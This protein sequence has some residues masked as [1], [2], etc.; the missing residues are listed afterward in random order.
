MTTPDLKHPP[1]KTPLVPA[2]HATAL[3][4]YQLAAVAMRRKIVEMGYVNH[5]RLHYGALMSMVEIM[6]ALYGAWLNVDPARPDWPERDRFVLSKGH[7]APALYVA[8]WLRG[9]F[10]ERHFQGFRRLGSILQGHP[11]RLKTP[12]VDCSSGS[13]GQ[14]MP[15]ACGMALGAKMDRAAYRVYCLLSDGEC[16]EGSVWE[17]AQIASN[18]G[19]GQLKVLMDRNRKS[20]YGWMAGRNEVEPLADKWRAFNWAVFE[21]DGHDLVSITA[22]LGQAEEVED[23]PAIIICRTIKGKGLPYVENYPTKP[24]ILLTEETYRECLAHLDQVES[25]LRDE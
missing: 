22:A 13:L 23:R 15:V 24:N 3:R 16:N 20:S 19:L 14:G 1:L 5:I 25:E 6:T 7:G 9:F 10:D 8:L 17:A 21:C 18:L 12:G 4:G 2:Q 11:D